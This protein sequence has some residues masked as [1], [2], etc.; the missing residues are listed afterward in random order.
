MSVGRSVDRP[1][2]DEVVGIWLVVELRLASA[3]KRRRDFADALILHL[4]RD[5]ELHV[6]GGGTREKHKEIVRAGG[7]GSRPSNGP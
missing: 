3:A 5:S 2:F 7:L 4:G 6:P 1:G